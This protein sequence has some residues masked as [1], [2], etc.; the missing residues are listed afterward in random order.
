MS[1]SSIV[2]LSG[3]GQCKQVL[4]DCLHMVLVMCEDVADLTVTRH[5]SGQQKVDT[6]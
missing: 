4:S 5:S 6:T 3:G 2:K 1:S